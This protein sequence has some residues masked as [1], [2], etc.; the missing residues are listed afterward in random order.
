LQSGI[1]E[2]EGAHLL[3]GFRSDAFY[4]HNHRCRAAERRLAAVSGNFTR[5]AVRDVLRRLLREADTAATVRGLLF[6][7]RQLLRQTVSLRAVL[8]VLLRLR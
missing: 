1:C 7:L 5:Q 6:R 4:R 8:C 3:R 2:G